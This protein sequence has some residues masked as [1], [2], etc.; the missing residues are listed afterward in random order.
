MIFSIYVPLS[1]FQ[2]LLT[3][4]KNMGRKAAARHAIEKIDIG[5]GSGASAISG[6][7]IV[8]QRANILQ[9]PKA[10]VVRATGNI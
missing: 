5:A 3:W 8:A 2:D 10:V 7:K 4:R 9:I 1:I 6:D